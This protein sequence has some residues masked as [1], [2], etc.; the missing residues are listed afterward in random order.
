MKKKVVRKPKK[1]VKHTFIYGG[2]E[3]GSGGLIWCKECGKDVEDKAH[4]KVKINRVKP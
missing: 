2:Y 3:V 4:F 1:L